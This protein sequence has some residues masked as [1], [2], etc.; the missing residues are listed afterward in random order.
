MRLWATQVSNI[1]LRPSPREDIGATREAAARRPPERVG[2]MLVKCRECAEPISNKARVCPHCGVRIRAR[3]TALGPLLLIFVLLLI[4]AAVT[5]TPQD[6]HPESLEV[7]ANAVNVGQRSPY[8]DMTPQEMDDL[9]SGVTGMKAYVTGDDAHKEEVA[10]IQRNASVMLKAYEEALITLYTDM[11]TATQLNRCGIRDDVWF[12]EVE[13]R[14]QQGIDHATYAQRVAFQIDDP[15]MEAAV[16]YARWR[17]DQHERF[18]MGDDYQKGCNGLKD[19]PFVK[20]F[21][22]LAEGRVSL[23]NLHSPELDPYLQ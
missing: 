1:R 3:S 5:D 18:M 10:D 15:K 23:A 4:W 21:D 19:M 8:S 2:S 9:V 7:A 17:V 11:W 12:S 16:A 22:F 20:R 6:A 14:I 13:A